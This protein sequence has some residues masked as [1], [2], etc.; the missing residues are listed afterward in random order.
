MWSTLYVWVVDRRISYENCS[1]IYSAQ[2]STECI[3]K[4]KMYY[5]TWWFSAPRHNLSGYEIQLTD[6][7]IKK[8]H[9]P[10]APLTRV[11]YC[12][13]RCW[14]RFQLAVLKHKIRQNLW[15]YNSYYIICLVMFVNVKTRQELLNTLVFF[16]FYLRIETNSFHFH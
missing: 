1:I 13:S 8:L 11:P 7:A 16:S 5:L 15:N 12:G 14:S 4:K 10:S 9:S 6:L 2:H 3:Y